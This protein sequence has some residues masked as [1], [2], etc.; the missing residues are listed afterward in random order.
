MPI[1]GSGGY[2]ALPDYC[3]EEIHFLSEKRSIIRDCDTAFEKPVVRRTTFPEL[4][5]KIHCYA[6]FF[7]ARN[8]ETLGYAAVYA[9]DFKKRGA[10]LTL[11]GVRDA[12]QHKG[13][14]KRLLQ[15]C[16]TASRQNGM[17]FL[18]LETHKGNANAIGFYRHMGYDICGKASESSIYM[19][20]QL[21]GDTEIYEGYF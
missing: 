8:A 2:N 13:V 7:A 1:I 4:M 20:K 19:K 15:C 17:A 12:H 16:E 14:G 18:T 6:M 9:N 10:Y 3:I 11:I 21:H 5:N